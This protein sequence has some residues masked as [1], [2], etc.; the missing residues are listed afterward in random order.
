MCSARMRSPVREQE[1]GGRQ[2]MRCDAMRSTPLCPGMDAS[3]DALSVSPDWLFTIFLLLLVTYL[4]NSNGHKREFSLTDTSIQHTFAVKERVPFWVAIVVAGAVPLVVIV[5]VGALWR[6]SFW[7]VHNGLLGLLLSLA[8]ATVVTDILKVTVG[9]PR[10]DLIDRCQ[11]LLSAMNAVPYGLANVTVCTVQTGRIIEDGFKSFPSGHSSFSFAGLGFLSFYLA[12]KMGVW[13]RSGYS[14]KA[15]IALFPLLGALLIA[16]SRTMDNRHHATDVLIGSLLGFVMAYISYR[17]YYPSLSS[18]HSHLP[19]S[20][21]H[22]SAPAQDILPIST[23][24]LPL[25][26]EEIGIESPKGTVSRELERGTT[27]DG[28]EAVKSRVV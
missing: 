17:L 2:L 18:R 12:G 24:S 15:W 1:E 4:T 19:F 25:R 21:R 27:V 16:I 23:S 6:R 7:D 14:I 9:R 26:D 28:Y 5:L 10:P 11:P 3:A 20:P 8:T 13:D 22:H